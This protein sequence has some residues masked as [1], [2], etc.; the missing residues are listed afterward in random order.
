MHKFSPR[1]HSDF[2]SKAS[3]SSLAL[4]LRNGVTEDAI[5]ASLAFAAISARTAV[6]YPTPSV[7]SISGS[8]RSLV[9][10]PVLGAARLI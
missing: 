1:C 8:C 2:V 6:A 4:A 7:P 5:A 10:H 9:D 3:S